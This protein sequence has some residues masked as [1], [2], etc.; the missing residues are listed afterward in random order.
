MAC[1]YVPGL[2]LLILIIVSSECSDIQTVTADDAVTLCRFNSSEIDTGGRVKVANYTSDKKAMVIFEWPKQAQ[3]AKRLSWKPDGNG[4]MCLHLKNVQKSDEGTYSCEMWRGWDRVRVT[5]MTLKVKDCKSLSAVKAKLDSSFRLQCSVDITPEKQRP[6][7]VSWAKLKGR[8]HEPVDSRRVG[9]D[10]TLIFQTVSYSDSGWY[11][12]N[13]VLGTTKRCV[14]VRLNVQADDTSEDKTATI[15]PNT[16]T[17]TQQGSHQEAEHSATVIAVVLS[18]A[19]GLT[20]ATVFGVFFYRRQQRRKV[21]AQRQTAGRHM[22]T[23]DIYI[24]LTPPQ[25]RDPANYR[26]SSLYED[27]EMNTCEYTSKVIITGL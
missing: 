10:N 15:I 14:D 13:Y 8:H 6:Q 2:F 20:I 4:L 16:P 18:V 9:P 11:R 3:Q 26:V 12:C 5:N 21:T 23:V 24:P 25:S 27:E 7:N 1:F 17:D 22:E 19:F